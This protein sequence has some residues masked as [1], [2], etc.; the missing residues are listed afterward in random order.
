MDRTYLSFYIYANRIHIFIEALRG[1]G[2]PKRICFMI[3]QNGK[4]LLMLPQAKK[5]FV[6]HG[7]P[8]KVY[9]GADS[10][11]ICSKKLCRILAGQHDWDTSRSYRVPGVI[12]AERQLAAFDLTKAEVIVKGSTP[13][14]FLGEYEAG[15]NP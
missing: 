5:D 11:E 1:I 7:V 6:S 10:M 15:N 9:S 12:I 8:Q 4:R 14:V 3:D 13:S 2:S